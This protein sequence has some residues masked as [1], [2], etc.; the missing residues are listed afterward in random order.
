MNVSLDSRKDF[1]ESFLN[2][3]VIYA[4][5]A[6]VVLSTV[7]TGL[8]ARSITHL[9][10]AV[11]TAEDRTWIADSIL[12][13]RSP[14][15]RVWSLVVRQNIFEQRRIHDEVPVARRICGIQERSDFSCNILCMDHGH[16]VGSPF[17]MH[18]HWLECLALT[19]TCLTAYIVR[20]S[21][22]YQST[23]RLCMDSRRQDNFGY[24]DTLPVRKFR[25]VCRWIPD[26]HQV[27]S[28]T[29][30][31][32]RICYDSLHGKGVPRLFVCMRIFPR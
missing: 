20:K 32:V 13:K 2:S 16:N 18:K 11:Y 30:V 14:N 27:P 23:D 3:L 6:S 9:A 1:G 24:E 19:C 25:E 17:R 29:A 4:I 26:F 10:C 15:V 8:A 31:V 12:S 22:Y 5:S 28:W 21:L 7:R